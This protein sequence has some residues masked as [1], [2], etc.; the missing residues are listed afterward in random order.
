[1][2]IHQLNYSLVVQLA[3]N[4]SFGQ[5]M[6]SHFSPP[7]PSLQRHPAV[8]RTCRCMFTCNSFASWDV[9]Y[10][11]EV[12]LMYKKHY[13][14][15]EQLLK[16]HAGSLLKPLYYHD[17]RSCVS[18]I[19]MILTRYSIHLLNCILH[20]TKLR[21]AKEEKNRWIRSDGSSMIK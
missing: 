3:P 17:Q 7:Y 19:C 9:Q 10:S 14:W 21:A 11:F 16:L 12:D 8:L 13:S 2:H 4:L 18:Y 5:T 1:M 6:R 15:I 20:H